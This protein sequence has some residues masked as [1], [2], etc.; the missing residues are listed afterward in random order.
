MSHSSDCRPLILSGDP[1]CREA[2]LIEQTNGIVEK[3]DTIAIQL[4]GLLESRYP[5]V[6]RKLGG[7]ERDALRQE[8]LEGIP[9]ENFGCWV[10]FPWSG[11]LVLHL[12]P[13]P[14]FHELRLNRNRYKVTS[15][16]Q[17]KL[18]G[19]TVAVVGLSAGNAASPTP[20]TDCFASGH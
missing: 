5:K 14:L 15:E 18:D 10:F 19:L 4:D 2:L 13:P 6:W 17:K 16:E 11:K 1:A 9:L 7:P 12:L 20:P 8:I 3:S